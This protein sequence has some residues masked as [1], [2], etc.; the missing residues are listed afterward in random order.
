MYSLMGK[1]VLLIVYCSWVSLVAQA[2]IAAGKVLYQQCSVCH[3]VEAKGNRLMNAPALAGQS[4][5]YLSRQLKHFKTGVRGADASDIF[6]VQMRAIVANLADKQA[7]NNV[8]GYIASIPM[9]YTG[10]QAG[11]DLRQ[12]NDLYQGHCSSCHGANAQGNEALN[13]PRLAGLD[14]VYLERQ[15]KNFKQGIRGAHPIDRFGRQMRLMARNS[16]ANDKE[17]HSVIAYILAQQEK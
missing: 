10:N 2:D 5:S 12:G 13:S 8:S 17:L 1:R 16:L 14:A 6:G 4:Q 11:G 7:I 15:F 3:G 9:I